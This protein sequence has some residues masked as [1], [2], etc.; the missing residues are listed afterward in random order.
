MYISEKSV[1]HLGDNNLDT[2]DKYKYLCV[3]VH[4]KNVFFPR[5]VA[6]FQG[7]F[8]V[9]FGKLQTKGTNLI[10]LDSKHSKIFI[11]HVFV[12]YKNTRLLGLALGLQK[13]SEHC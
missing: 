3:I 6:L 2:V 1:F 7:Q 5:T 10:T 13:H 12:C 9:R 4:E 8:E 11:T